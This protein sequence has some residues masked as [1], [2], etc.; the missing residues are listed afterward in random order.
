M[1]RAHRSMSNRIRAASASAASGCASNPI[2][3]YCATTSGRLRISVVAR[4]KHVDRLL[5]HV[6][7]A[8][9]GVPRR[10]LEIG[11]AGLRHGRHVRQ[12]GQSPRRR[13]R[14]RA[15]L[16]G[17]DRRPQPA[18]GIDDEVDVVAQQRHRELG[19]PAIGHHREIELLDRF[20]QQRR[21]IIGGAGARCADAHHAGLRPRG[22]DPLLERLVRRR[23]GVDE[24]VGELADPDDRLHLRGAD[25]AL[26][27]T[28]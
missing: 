17:F 4:A 8:V 13:H 22:G 16:L 14:E 7:R 15:H 2:V 1:T 18:I 20:E 26:R 5:R 12:L 23:G 6:L 21:E 11:H 24:Q 19:R 28:G 27:E 3:A 10:H 25:R 9:E